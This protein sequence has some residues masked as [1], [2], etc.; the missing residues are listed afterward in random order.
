[1]ADSES[2]KFKLKFSG[3][4]AIDPN[5]NRDGIKDKD[6]TPLKYLSNFWRTLELPLTN[7]D[8]NL[9]LNWSE[10]YNK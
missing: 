1:M 2:F 8:V 6:D 4:T 3:N 5:N 7:C 10:N 9:M